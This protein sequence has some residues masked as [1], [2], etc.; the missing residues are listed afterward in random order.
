MPTLGT[1]PAGAPL[2]AVGIPGG[3][4]LALVTVAL[5]WDLRGPDDVPT[6]A[7]VAAADVFTLASPAW[8]HPE[9]VTDPAALAAVTADALAYLRAMA[10][11]DPAAGAALFG[12]LGVSQE[13]RV[14]TLQVVHDTAVER[15]DLLA[16]P[17][18]L[19]A[20]FD[21]YRWTPPA[22]DPR[23][24]RWGLGPA[25]LRVTRYLTTQMTGSALEDSAHGQA[26]YADPGSPWRTRF[27]RDQVM[28]GAYRTGEAAGAAKPLVWLPEDDVHDA[29]MQG[30]VQ[31]RLGDGTVHTYGVDVPNGIA[32]VP[33]HRGRAQARYWYFK[34]LASGPKGWGPPGSPEIHLRA[35]VSVA[36]DVYNLGVGAL[37]LVDH[38]DGKGGT[39]LRLAVLA[40]SGGAFQPNLCQLDWYGGAFP[41]H[42]ALYAAWRT[43]PEHV[44]ASVLVA[45]PYGES[46]G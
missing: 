41:S 10:G 42:D 29:I 4:L 16:D 12:E 25:E 9:V 43:L 37:I 22:T 7:T 11:T 20:H 19:S 23:V 8:A 36:G 1:P 15:P 33:S 34:E 44:G 2:A 3:V 32:Y 14:R 13:A 28:S 26:L 6:G 31:V 21:V 38:P 39:T 18:W 24:A 30:S 40:D 45:R 35:G 17:G 5:A 46:G 27:T